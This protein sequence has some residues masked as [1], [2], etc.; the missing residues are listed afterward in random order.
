MR[1]GKTRWH[2]P[3]PVK[4]Y[5]LYRVL[6]SPRGGGLYRVV[7]PLEAWVSTGATR[8]AKW[9]PMLD[10]EFEQVMVAPGTRIEAQP[11]GAVR[12]LDDKVWLVGLG[13][14]A[15]HSVEPESHIVRLQL[16]RPSSKDQWRWYACLWNG[17]WLS[18]IAG[19][20]RFGL[21]RL[22]GAIPN[23]P[24]GAKDPDAWEWVDNLSFDT[25]VFR[26]VGGYEWVYR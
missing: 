13:R 5:G 16:A 19:P 26:H 3:T 18:G 24:D 1:T 12:D 25:M 14:E 6:P 10:V 17:T 7:R 9:S 20:P 11:S 22:I 21:K 15:I 4:S 23:A 2:E 8:P